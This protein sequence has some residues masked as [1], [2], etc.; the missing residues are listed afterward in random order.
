MSKEFKKGD[1]VLLVLKRHYQYW[2]IMMALNKLGAIAIPATNQLK[3]HDF[4]YR[5]NSAGVKAIVCT[6]DGDTARHIVLSVRSGSATTR[7]VFIG[8]RPRA[9]HSTVA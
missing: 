6:A 3:E 7:L 9:T 2:F 5:Y 1:R 4:E 8:S